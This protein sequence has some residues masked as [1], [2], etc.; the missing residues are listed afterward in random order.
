MRRL[1]VS[2]PYSNSH[3]SYE[4]VFCF[5]S[6]DHPL[7]LCHGPFYCGKGKRGEE[8]KG[9]WVETHKLEIR[10]LYFA[11]KQLLTTFEHVGF[12]SAAQWSVGSKADIRVKN[13]INTY[14]DCKRY[15]H[16]WYFPQGFCE[17]SQLYLIFLVF[18]VLHEV[19][20]LRLKLVDPVP[21]LLGPLPWKHNDT[22]WR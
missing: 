7:S 10:L 16:S 1:G 20:L 9:A 11:L 12:C 3:F 22:K 18:H 4:C 21:H 2:P 19:K 13:K 8:K 5:T 6:S 15:F 17:Q 14:G